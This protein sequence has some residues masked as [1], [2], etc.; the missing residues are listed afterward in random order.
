MVGAD[1]RVGVR[2]HYGGEGL[3]MV[4]WAGVKEQVKLSIC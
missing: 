1:E 4:V 2:A 3:G